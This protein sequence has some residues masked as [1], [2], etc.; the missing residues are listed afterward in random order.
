MTG[1]LIVSI[2]FLAV[3]ALASACSP[4]PSDE[5]QPSLQSTSWTL[6]ALGTEGDLTPAR[7]EPEATIEFDAG[8]VSGSAGCNQYFGSYSADKNGTFSV[9]EVAWT[10][11]ACPQ[12]GVMEQEQEFLDILLAAQTYDVTGATLTVAGSEGQLLF[13]SAQ[14]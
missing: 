14:E 2:V 7:E 4:G 3:V 13:T 5:G 12:P 9:A 8:E 10:E 1:R 11:K 6:A